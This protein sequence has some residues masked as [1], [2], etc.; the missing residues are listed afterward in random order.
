MITTNYVMAQANQKTY[1]GKAK[2]ISNNIFFLFLIMQMKGNR[3]IDYRLVFSSFM[4]RLSEIKKIV[5][6]TGEEW[7]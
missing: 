2:T 7:D 5:V 1:I 6:F 3:K 4:S